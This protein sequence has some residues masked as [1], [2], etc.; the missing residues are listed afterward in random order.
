MSKLFNA[1]IQKAPDGK[2]QD[3]RGLLLVKKGATD[4]WVFRYSLHGKRREMGL[5]SWPVVT[6]AEA[7]DRHRSATQRN[8]DRSYLSRR[9]AEGCH[10]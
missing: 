8:G 9:S 4:K 5:G 2:L 7:P 1:T 3:G 6:L 10:K